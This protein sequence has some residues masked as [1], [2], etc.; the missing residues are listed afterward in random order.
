MPMVLGPVWRNWVW[1]EAGCAT[2]GNFWTPDSQKYSI[3]DVAACLHFA[4]IG[5]GRAGRDEITCAACGDRQ[6]YQW[7]QRGNFM[8]CWCRPRRQCDAR[9]RIFY[10]AVAGGA[11]IGRETGAVGE[12]GSGLARPHEGT[13]S[14]L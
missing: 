11:G 1:R 7:P 14:L 4:E 5:V 8:T 9:P 12:G 13:V 2:Y 10:K 3:C 6:G